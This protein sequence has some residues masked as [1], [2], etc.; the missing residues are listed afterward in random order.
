MPGSVIPARGHLDR[1]RAAA[2]SS[3]SELNVA[4]A[5]VNAVNVLVIVVAGCGPVVVVGPS[6]FSLDGESI[7]TWGEGVM[8]KS[9]L[10]PPRPEAEDR[11]KLF[12]DPDAVF[13][14]T[15]TIESVGMV[16][17]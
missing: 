15:G 5:D 10:I 12:D 16:C 2:A 6:L 11:K 3:S 4:A 8:V 9:L 7:V 1:R 13:D 17:C 14:S